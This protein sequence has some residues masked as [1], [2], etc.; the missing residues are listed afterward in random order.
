MT[1][2][3]L[4]PLRAITR[5]PLPLI[6]TEEGRMLGI[7]L[8]S[9]K[10]VRI[11]AGV[12]TERKPYLDLPNWKRYA[13]RVHAFVRSHPHAVLCLES[14][15]VVLGI[16]YFNEPKDIHVYDPNRTASRR[17]GD[18]VVHTSRDPRVIGVTAGIQTTSPLDTAV[19]MVRVLPP[20]QGLAVADAAISP[21]QQGFTDLSALRELSDSQQSSRGRARSRWAWGHA[22]ARAESPGESVSRAVIG[23]C[24]FEHPELQ[25]EFDYDGYGDRVDFLFPSKGVIGESDG[26]GKY[27]LGDT[28]KAAQNLADEK[29][30]EDRLRRHGHPFARWELVDVWRVDPLAKSLRAAGVPVCR[31]REHA[32][33]ATLAHR[34]REKR[35]PADEK[36]HSA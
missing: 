20:A 5:S 3:L 9:P 11:R 29:R 12:Y 35:S 24:G 30:R 18:V 6:T 10:Y 31:P 22:D 26:W 19:D 25:H 16:P 1:D 23:W 17:F 13:V 32:M 14:A 8:P 33:L 2:T 34:P 36:P 15:A 4:L 28:A 27:A 21:S 7:R